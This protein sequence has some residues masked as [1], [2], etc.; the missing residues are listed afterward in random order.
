[1]EDD[2]SI[3]GIFAMT[4]GIPIRGLAMYFNVS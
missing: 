2:L 3:S 1:M 4:V